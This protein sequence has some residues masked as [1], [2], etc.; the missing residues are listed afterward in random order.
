MHSNLKTTPFLVPHLDEYSETVGYK[1]EGQNKSALFIPDIDK[2]HVWHKNIVDE[3]K[4]V[5]Y[6]FLD[7]SFFRDAK[8]DRDMSKIPYPFTTE[9]T[10]LFK[11]ESKET[12]NKIH[13][14]ILIIPILH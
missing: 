14:S 7:T 3:V 12:K 4:K 1:I 2:W 13:L 11:N 9:T 5:D 10:T 8:L 6:A